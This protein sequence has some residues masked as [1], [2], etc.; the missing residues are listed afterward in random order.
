MTSYLSN[1]PGSFSRAACSEPIEALKNIMTQFMYYYKIII[2]DL[3]G[4][5][6]RAASR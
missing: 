1:I 6:S 2:I 3:P 4:I 5:R